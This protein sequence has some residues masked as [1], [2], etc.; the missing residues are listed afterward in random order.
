M[1]S[2]RDNGLHDI[3]SIGKRV[4]ILGPQD[5]VVVVRQEWVGVAVSCGEDDAV[6][7]SDDLE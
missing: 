6:E 1:R 3:A 7:A 4:S 2:I 5:C